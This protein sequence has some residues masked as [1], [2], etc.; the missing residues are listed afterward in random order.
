M[1]NKIVFYGVLIGILVLLLSGSVYIDFIAN[2]S[3]GMS[4]LLISQMFVGIS[5]VIFTLF[6]GLKFLN[7]KKSSELMF[8]SF[9]EALFVLGLV[10]FNYTYGYN[11]AVND[12]NYIEYMEYASMEFNVFIYIVFVVVL[13][14]L[15]L[16][17]YVNEKLNMFNKKQISKEEI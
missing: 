17:L 3:K 16:N 15:N 8:I 5:G 4:F 9:L 1:K 10:I 14:L 12:N 7:N 6:A 11:N 2:T 13:G